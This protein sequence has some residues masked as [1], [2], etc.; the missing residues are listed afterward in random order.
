MR[1]PVIL[2]KTSGGLHS[3]LNDQKHARDRK[4]GELRQRP[5]LRRRRD[6][7]RGPC[8]RKGARADSNSKP[9]RLVTGTAFFLTMWAGRGVTVT[10]AGAILCMFACAAY[11][12]HLYSLSSLVVA[13]LTGLLLVLFGVL[14]LVP[15]LVLVIQRVWQEHDALATAA[16]VLALGLALFALSAT[17]EA[18]SGVDKKIKQELIDIYRKERPNDGEEVVANL[19]VAYRGREPE[20]LEKIKAKFVHGTRARSIS[21]EP[22][23]L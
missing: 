12:P 16:A 23:R 21:P 11:Q 22:R 9:G 6:T 3:T 17:V 18:A 8:E 1:R 5:S 10:T 15:M 19:L 20:L 13:L 7:A 14:G 4:G 2:W